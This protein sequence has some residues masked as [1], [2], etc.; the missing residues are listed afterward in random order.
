MRGRKC[1][2]SQ[3]CG[4]R[5]SVL[6]VAGNAGEAPLRDFFIIQAA[7]AGWLALLGWL[8][9]AWLAGW[10]AAAWLAAAW[11]AGWPLPITILNNT[12]TI[13]NNTITILNNNITILNTN[14]NNNTLTL[15]ENIKKLGTRSFSCPAVEK[16]RSMASITI[17]R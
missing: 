4:P 2:A 1:W 7:L 16:R 11:L 5:S 6:G 3:T 9:A 17:E 14:N 12:I 8:A 15:K 13:L 10:L